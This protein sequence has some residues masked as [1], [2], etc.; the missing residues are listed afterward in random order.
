MHTPP[1]KRLLVVD[2]A[3]I[4]RAIIKDTAKK[5]GW[6]IVGEA[7]NGAEAVTQFRELKPDMTTL[8]IVMPEMDGVEALRVIRDE[9]PQARVVM[10]SAIDQRAKLNECIQLGA[11]DFIVKPFDKQRLLS[12]FQTYLSSESPV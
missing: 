3:M 1:S 12:L 11:L 7:T 8:D 9:D 5:A 4:M 10:I 2:D 6:E